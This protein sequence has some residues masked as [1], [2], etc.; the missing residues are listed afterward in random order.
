MKILKNTLR[1]ISHYP[2]AIFGA[3]II[4]ILIAL[5]IFAVS[6]IPYDEAIQLWR[7]GEDTV[8]RNPKMYHR[9]GLIILR[10]KV[11]LFLSQ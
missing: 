6:T 3:L 7:G 5:A 1:E 11:C 10:I 2:S 8:Y 4:L 9:R